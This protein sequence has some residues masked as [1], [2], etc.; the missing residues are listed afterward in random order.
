MLA[1]AGAYAQGLVAFGNSN[2]IND[3]DGVTGLSAPFQAELYA[4]TSAS[5]LTPITSSI[6]PFIGGGF[7]FNANTVTVPGI[8]GGANAFLAI[9]VWNPA[10]GS[11]FE[12]ASLKAGAHVG[13]DLA[14]PF[15]LALGGAGTPPSAPAV[16]PSSV[17]GFNLS[18]VQA[19]PEP[20]TIALGLLGAGALFLRRRK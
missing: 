13:S 20:T 19:V 17:A 12:A 7:F 11:T 10:D 5:S 18:I 9:A 2:P 16:I 15:Q 1:G 4:G 14:N 3:A 6:T 8:A